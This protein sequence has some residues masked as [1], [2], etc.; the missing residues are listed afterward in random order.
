M[1]DY[2]V[3][4][5][6]L[7]KKGTK[8]AKNP[9]KHYPN[10]NESE[11]LRKIMAETSLSEVEVRSI[12]TYRKVLAEASKEGRIAK[13]SEVEKYY[14]GLIKKA[15]KETKLAKEH[16]LTLWVLDELLKQESRFNGRWFFRHDVQS[17]KSVIENY[18]KKKKDK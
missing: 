14:Q 10:K 2:T 15:C 13:R 9:D 16:P 5:R 6:Y 17:A 3:H 18:G 12:K 4:E 7:T 8:I 1:N 11:M